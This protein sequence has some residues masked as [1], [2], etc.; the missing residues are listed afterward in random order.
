MTPEAKQKLF[1]EIREICDW[2]ERFGWQKDKK[3]LRYN[4]IARAYR[5]F[6]LMSKSPASAKKHLHELCQMCFKD[7]DFYV[8]GQ[9]PLTWAWTWAIPTKSN[10]KKWL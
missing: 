10:I 8:A 6:L 7:S 1:S 4:D 3:L 9:G 2:Y 5:I